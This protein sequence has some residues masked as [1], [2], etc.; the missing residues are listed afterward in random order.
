MVSALRYNIEVTGSHNY[1]IYK[2]AKSHTRISKRRDQGALS[3]SKSG[4]Q[5]RNRD[6]EAL[7][8]FG[9]VIFGLNWKIKGVRSTKRTGKD[10]K[11]DAYTDFQS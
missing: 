3:E 6:E 4:I 10:R 9:V 8:Q 11:S 7:E 1:D 5:R 2:P